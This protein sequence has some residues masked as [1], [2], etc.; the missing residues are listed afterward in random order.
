MICNHQKKFEHFF[1]AR[2]YISN[3]DFEV[4][5]CP[6]CGLAQTIVKRQI[7]LDSKHYPDDYYGKEKRYGAFSSK[8]VNYLARRRV[9]YLGLLPSAGSVLDIGCGQGW[10]LKQFKNQ[11]W[12][13][14][15]IEV[16]DIAAFHARD[17]LGLKIIVGENATSTV[18]SDQYDVIGLWHVL[19]HLE[20]PAIQLKEIHR[21]L[22]SNGKVLIGVPNFGSTEA[23]LGKDGWFH[24]DVPRHLYHFNERSLS[25]ILKEQGFKITKKQYF[26]PEYDFFSFVQTIQNR[27]GISMNLLYRTL[28]HGSLN[29][30]SGKT[31]LL[32]WLALIITTPL[33]SIASLIWVPLTLLVN[34]GSSLVLI[35]EKENA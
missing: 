34:N 31:S 14:L 24:L 17:Q 35:L 21:L 27:L 9:N 30:N 1:H 2:D 3:Q 19:E 16:S 32:D 22:K 6:Q 23:R 4:T 13:T 15:G 26:V 10:F 18:N 28:R 5:R 11:G 29:S 12:E 8:I 25:S 20:N 7:T 33:L